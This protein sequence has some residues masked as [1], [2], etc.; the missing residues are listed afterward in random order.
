MPPVLQTPPQIMILRGR[1]IL[2]AAG[3]KVGIC[4]HSK[5]GSMNVG[6]R[7]VGIDQERKTEPLRN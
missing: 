5:I 7:S 1:K 4:S 2:P 3:L 6:M